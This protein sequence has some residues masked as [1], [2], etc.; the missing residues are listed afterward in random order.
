MLGREEAWSGFLGTREFGAGARGAVS[1]GNGGRA[2]VSGRLQGSRGRLRRLLQPLFTFHLHVLGLAQLL[3]PGLLVL[4]LVVVHVGLGLWLRGGGLGLSCRGLQACVGRA[5]GG[6]AA[7]PGQRRGLGTSLGGL[8]L[9][10][11]G[12]GAGGR[13]RQRDAHVF[14]RYSP[15][16]GGGTR[17]GE[18]GGEEGTG[19]GRRLPRGPGDPE[20][21][22][23]ASPSPAG[24]PC[25]GES[26][27]GAAGPRLPRRPLARGWGPAPGLQ[28]SLLPA[29]GSLLLL[30]RCC[31]RRLYGE[32][33]RRQGF[34]LP[35]S[36]SLKMAAAVAP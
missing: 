21:G 15:N 10:S 11:G 18:G 4:L 22:P 6:G 9:G 23:G 29:P 33:S 19:R 31:R 35:L 7:G 14:A 26:R 32:R 36:V 12:Q 2:R 16:L 13:R 24:Y 17:S 20:L 30:S 34:S 28:A 25:C 5:G 1:K 8:R 3:L 27:G